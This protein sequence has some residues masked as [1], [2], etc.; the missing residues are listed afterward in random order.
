ME[1]AT[2]N[3]VSSL[4]AGVQKRSVTADIGPYA[5]RM[6]EEQPNIKTELQTECDRL[7]ESIYECMGSRQVTRNKLESAAPWILDDAFDKE[8][9]SH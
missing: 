6:N 2:R 7:L 8:Y 1:A 5:S 4:V 9:Q 3:E